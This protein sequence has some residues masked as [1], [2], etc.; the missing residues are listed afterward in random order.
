MYSYLLKKY[1]IENYKTQQSTHI[2]NHLCLSKKYNIEAKPNIDIYKA[3]T[4]WQITIC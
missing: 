2:E 4:F 3:S 1:F